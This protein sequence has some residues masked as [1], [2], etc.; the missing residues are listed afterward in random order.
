MKSSAT[1]CVLHRPVR[2]MANDDVLTRRFDNLTA[3]YLK[4]AT[5]LSHYDR[6]RYP[7]PCV[8][9]LKLVPRATIIPATDYARILDIPILT[10]TIINGTIDTVTASQSCQSFSA[11]ENFQPSNS[12]VPIML[13]YSTG[14]YRLTPTVEPPTNTSGKMKKAILFQVIN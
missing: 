2:M 14:R 5:L 11:T 10:D 4:I 7:A 13:H 3:Q 9:D 12:S 6:V 1:T 8:G